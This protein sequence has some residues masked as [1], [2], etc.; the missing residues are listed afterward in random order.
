MMHSSTRGID[1]RCLSDALDHYVESGRYSRRGPNVNVAAHS[2][3]LRSLISALLPTTRND[4][5]GATFLFIPHF[6]MF[7]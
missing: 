2:A 3:G 1:G 4:A 6:S 7:T 5:T